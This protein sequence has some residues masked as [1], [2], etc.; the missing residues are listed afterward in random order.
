M[1]NL[2]RSELK[3]MYIDFLQSSMD[4]CQVNS[5]MMV[6]LVLSKGLRALSWGFQLYFFINDLVLLA[7]DSGVVHGGGHVWSNLVILMTSSKEDKLGCTS[8]KLN[9]WLEF[10]KVIS[11]LYQ[12]WMVGAHPLEAG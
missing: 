7:C 5:D 3:T 11:G 1:Q 8:V 2:A 10:L 12:F 9:V 4:L 6:M